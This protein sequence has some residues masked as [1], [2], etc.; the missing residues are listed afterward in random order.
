MKILSIRTCQECNKTYENTYK[1]N[2]FNQSKKIC[3]S[4]ENKQLETNSKRCLD[5]NVTKP[6]KDFYLNR[7][8]PTYHCKECQKKQ[9]QKDRLNRTQEQRQKEKKRKKGY[10]ARS[11][12]VNILKQVKC[13]A[14]QKGLSFNLDSSDIIVPKF[15]PI[16]NI[17]LKTNTEGFNDNSPSIDRVDNH[18]GYI[19][20]NVCFISMRGNRLKSDGTADEHEKIA[21]YIREKTPEDYSI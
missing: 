3:K 18:L 5:C 7:G 6:F 12:E 11:L 15:C 10:W 20:Q 9:C 2:G 8:L 17:E 4:C 21:I 14:K 1:E 13:R 16:F 19:K